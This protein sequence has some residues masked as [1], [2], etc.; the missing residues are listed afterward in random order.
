VT[1]SPFLRLWPLQVPWVVLAVLAT[2]PVTDAL[3]G[4]SSATAA[5]V[6]LIVGLAWTA[7]LVAMLVP[8]SIGLTVVRLAVPAAI[9]AVGAAAAV[10]DERSTIDALAL[11]AAA[12]ATVVVLAPW[13]IDAFVDGS[14]YGPERRLALRTPL[15]VLLVAIA[16]WA[17]TVAGATAGPLLLAAGWWLPG[18]AALAVGAP[19][20]ALGARALHQLSRRWLV[21][22]P[23]G[24]VLHDQ[25]TMPEPQ[26][27]LRQTMARLGPALVD[28]P[29]AIDAATEAERTPDGA[30]DAVEDLTAGA[31]GLV[32]EL[33]L[34]EPVELLVR[35]GRGTT[36]RPVTRVRFSPGRPAELLAEATRRRLPVG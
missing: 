14:S 16:T 9:V 11:L 30:A 17:A 10:G 20:A 13:T 5:I 12:V 22:V 8:R 18:T 36:L 29:E 15:P 2:V 31:S 33:E 25:L 34:T 19:V 21:L 6:W 26:L 7:A 1:S 24:M 27:F 35:N 4:Q 28:A 32:V 23:T 3:A